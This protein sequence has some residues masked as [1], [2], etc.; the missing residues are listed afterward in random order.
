MPFIHLEKLLSRSVSQA[1]LAPK[2]AHSKGLEEFTMV[3]EK[4]FG[5]Q[6]S[7]KVK[8]L[9]LKERVLMVACLSSALVAAITDRQRLIL[10]EVNRPYRQAVVEQIRF[11]T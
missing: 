1:G 8:P 7:G 11:L 5:P 4:S 9:Y 3:I 10:E 6:V 2:L